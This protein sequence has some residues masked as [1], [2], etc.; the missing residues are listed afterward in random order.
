[1]LIISK[2]IEKCLGL[3]FNNSDT[4]YWVQVRHHEENHYGLIKS[5]KMKHFI[6]GPEIENAGGKVKASWDTATIA[7]EPLCE[8]INKFTELPCFDPHPT[9]RKVLVTGVLQN[10]FIFCGCKSRLHMYRMTSPFSSERLPLNP[11][12]VITEQEKLSPKERKFDTD[13]AR[14]RLNIWKKTHSHLCISSACSFI[15]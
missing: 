13:E 14:D 2:V 8:P 9:R 7:E 10:L 11:E 6:N 4:D 5:S 1:M 15:Q 3:V 12:E